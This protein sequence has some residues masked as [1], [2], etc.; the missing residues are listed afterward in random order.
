MKWTASTPSSRRICIAASSSCV[1]TIISVS[2]PV[3]AV[4]RAVIVILFCCWAPGVAVLAILQ[5]WNLVRSPAAT[6][7]T[8][9][10]T[11]IVLSQAVLA[12]HLWL[13]VILTG[14]LAAA[15]LLLFAAAE[16]LP[17][18]VRWRE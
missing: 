14:Y 17:R 7:V 15:C 18:L 4:V 9:I 1:A 12:I 2:T 16:L 3:P 11:I 5:A 13:P 6:I 10:S 8:S